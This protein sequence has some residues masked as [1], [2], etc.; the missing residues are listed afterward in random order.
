MKNEVNITV[1]GGGSNV[2]GGAISSGNDI[3]LSLER[4]NTI[5]EVNKNR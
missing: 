4:L 3:I 1:R 5:V 2:S